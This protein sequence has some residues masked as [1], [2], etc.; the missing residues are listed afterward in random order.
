VMGKAQAMRSACNAPINCWDEFVVTVCYL[1]NHT[2]V[3]LQDGHTPF[4]KWFNR[5]PDLS[6]LHEIGCQAFV[7]IQN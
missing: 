7:L 6:H 3:K 5:I 4:K 1:T 2:P